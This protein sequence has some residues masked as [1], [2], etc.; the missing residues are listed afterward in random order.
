MA[1][2]TGVTAGLAPTA[3]G[4]DGFAPADLRGLSHQARRWLT[5]LLN[6][7][8][9]Q[10]AWPEAMLY[11]RVVALAKD[12]EP[13]AEDPMRYRLLTML[14]AVYRVW[15]KIRLRDMEQWVAGG[16]WRSFMGGG[17]GEGG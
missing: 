4:P 16:T 11:G 7:V 12:A 9:G 17:P 1:K 13:S 5:N 8:E 3:A 6:L 10:G 15:A 14:A 2:V